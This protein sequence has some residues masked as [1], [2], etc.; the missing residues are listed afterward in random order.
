MMSNFWNDHNGNE[1]TA[2]TNDRSPVPS[3]YVVAPSK[4]TA[5]VFRLHFGVGQH[6]DSVVG[7]L[8]AEEEV[9]K[10]DL[11]DH[12]G[13][14]EQLADEEPEGVEPVGAPVQVEVAHDVIDLR[15]LAV[16]GHDR[17]L[18]KTFV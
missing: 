8:V 17:L 2:A 3:A 6:I 9:R 10:V 14:I 18:V 12:V 13:Q 5:P 16:R 1:R 11:P 7:E 4:L 15:R